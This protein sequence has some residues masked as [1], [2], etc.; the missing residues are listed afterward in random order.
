M[1][2]EVVLSEP[3]AGVEL[4]EGALRWP[5]CTS[6]PRSGSA[7]SWPLLASFLTRSP[8]PIEELARAYFEAY[9]PEAKG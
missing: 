2:V 5:G 6:S 7:R 8:P 1:L 4:V 9:P 3:V